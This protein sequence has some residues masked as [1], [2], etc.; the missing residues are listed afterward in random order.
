MKNRLI[1][2][3]LFLSSVAQA[4][5]SN[6]FDT[7]FRQDGGK[8]LSKNDYT[9]ADKRLGGWSIIATNPNTLHGTPN[10]PVT[11]RTYRSEH[12]ALTDAT[13]VRVIY[14][15]YRTVNYGE[16]PNTNPITIGAA[17]QKKGSS[18]SDQS[19]ST[20]PL[21][22]GGKRYGICEGSALLISD[23]VSFNVAANERFYVRSYA[24]AMLA[25]A[26][27][28]PALSTTTTGGTLPASSSFFVSITYAFLDGS[29]SAPSTGTSITTGSGSTNSIT[30]SAP[31]SIAPAI[32]YRVWMT[33]AG[34][35]ATAIYYSVST[36]LPFS[37]NATI[38]TVVNTYA[39]SI[40]TTP[41]VPGGGSFIGSTNNDGRDTGEGY[42]DGEL[43]YDN[44]NITIR[45]G[46]NMYYP[47]AILGKTKTPKKTVGLIGDSIMSG[48]GD[49]GYPSNRGGFGVRALCNQYEMG[50]NAST[51]PLYAYTYVPQGSEQAVQFADR[52]MN[53]LRLGLTELCGNVI[54]NYGTNDLSLGVS[55]IKGSLLTIAKLY[56][57]RGIKFFTCTILPRT[58]STD[59][60]A[61]I[62][63]QATQGTTETTRLAVNAWLRDTGATGFVA[64][65]A[66]TGLVDVIDVCKYVEVNSANV[67][68]QDGGF[69]RIPADGTLVSGSVTGGN[70]SI[71]ISDNTKSFT[72]LQYAG[73]SIKFTS[74]GANNLVRCLNNSITNQLLWNDSVSPTPAVGDSYII[75]NVAT[76]DGTHPT[77]QGHIWMAQAVQEKLPQL[78]Y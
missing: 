76:Q 72:R 58:N 38:T 37:S 24:Q 75:T 33:S 20:V 46:A 4:Q 64:Q 39:P 71:G 66:A 27:T 44:Q 51:D 23:P 8:G 34:S 11:G 14:A 43:T 7:I 45:T 10:N 78:Q 68:T 63:N 50:Y 16:Y 17:L 67:L 21:G 56:T 40:A 70:S 69:W 30:V 59:G 29:N 13:Q 65:A 26:P 5:L 25:T 55:S 73:Y 22:F 6:T 28:S 53:R 77:S 52:R 12:I 1:I 47:V 18:A 57:D 42:S 60:W 41:V 9:N 31:A 48:T 3:L 19:Q 2:A 61:T 15:N 54:C 35:A 32:G 74:G 62:S 36:V 49:A